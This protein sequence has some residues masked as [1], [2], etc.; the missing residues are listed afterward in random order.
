MARPATATRD[1][2]PGRLL[3]VDDDPAMRRGLAARLEAAGYAVVAVADGIAMRSELLRPGYDIVVLDSDL[4]PE[5]GVEL[6]AGLRTISPVPIVLLIPQ[7]RPL[8]GVRGLEMGADDY[9][10]KPVDPRE[11]LARLRSVLRRA[12]ALPSNLSPS[13]ARCARFGG[14][15]LDF[16][17]RHLESEHGQLILLPGVE[18][19]IL[20]ML[21]EHAPAVLTRAQL[22]QLTSIRQDDAGPRA[23]DLQI[24][25]L[26]QKIGWRLIRTVRHEG[27]VLAAPVSLE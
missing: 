15:T 22:G 5:D 2:P 17:R 14:W 8:D 25:R 20:R 1:T 10:A 3:L 18:F 21:A 4:V 9:V 7:D 27:Y 12:R 23:V 24:S 11:L 26:R 6:C 16:E 13:S 19:R